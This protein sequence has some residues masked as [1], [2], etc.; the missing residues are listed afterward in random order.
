MVGGH[1]QQHGIGLGHQ[2]GQG[3]GGG[4][5]AANGLQHQLG[6]TNALFLQLLG[7]QKTVFCVAHQDGTRLLDA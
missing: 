7:C 1:G 2:C 6:T 4:R 3:Q 5:I